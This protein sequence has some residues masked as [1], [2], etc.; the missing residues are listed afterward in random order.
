MKNER[1]GGRL[2]VE[3]PRPVAIAQYIHDYAIPPLNEAFRDT[4]AAVTLCTTCKV[5][6]KC[7]QSAATLIASR[8]TS[9]G[10]HTTKLSHSSWI[11]LDTPSFMGFKQLCLGGLQNLV[12]EA[13]SPGVCQAINT[14]HCDRK[15][16][17]QQDSLQPQLT[18]KQ[19]RIAKGKRVD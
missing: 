16:T 14:R 12:R 1:G 11:S 17:Q 13:T 15:K 2:H 8:S 4:H 3:T 5:L 7:Q 9:T 6:K 10:W 19:N 18:E